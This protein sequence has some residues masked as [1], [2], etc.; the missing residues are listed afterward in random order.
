MSLALTLV[1]IGA[2]VAFYI[3]IGYPILLAVFP[4]RAAP[5]V[6]KD[7]RYETTVSVIVAVYNGA[8]FVRA[9]LE[10]LLDLDYPQD[11]M[12]IIIVSDGSTDATESIVREFAGHN[13]A[14]LSI[15]RGGKAAALNV[16]LQQATGE[17]LFLT[18]VRQ[19]LDR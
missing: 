4:F 3:L 6:A 12:N 14:L 19:P 10:T 1:I 18:D 15:P 7:L 9:K 2:C 8:A 13:I 16:G 5:P 17:I 11:L